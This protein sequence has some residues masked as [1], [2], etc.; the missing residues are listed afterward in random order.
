MRPA[1][2]RGGGTGGPGWIGRALAIAVALLALAACGQRDDAAPPPDAEAEPRRADL[3][4]VDAENLARLGISVERAGPGSIDAFTELPGE[5]RPN[6]DRLAHIVARYPGVVRDVRRTVGDRVKA[7]DVLAIVE[8]STSLAPYSLTTAIDGIVIDKHITKGEAI[9]AEK[10]AFVVADLDDVWIDL[11][12]YQKDLDK[13]A[14]GQRVRI[15]AGKELP[16]AEGAISYIT[17]TVD[18]PTR[19]AT[20]R[21][22]LDN[23]DRR[24]R[25][26][27][28]VTGRVLA[29]FRADLVVPLAAIQTYEGSSVVFAE[30]PG[31][32]A[33]RPVI[34]G[35]RGESQ[36]AVL[37]GLEPGERYVATGSFL[38]KAELGKSEAEH[39]H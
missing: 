19:T 38:I 22:V 2:R 17:P 37:S 16:P 8:A 5:V 32:F 39:G 30:R 9:D 25:P 23:R 10:G 1:M 35:A 4:E 12:V 11:A 26:G 34:L 29:P 36:V 15:S 18:P 14:V 28:F 6:G 31:G 3:V 27:M 21:V 7:G 13:V 20:A 33:P 24:W